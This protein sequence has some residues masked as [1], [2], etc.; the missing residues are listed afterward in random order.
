VNNESPIMNYC[1]PSLG[2]IDCYR[3]LKVDM[4]ND[5]NCYLA[6]FLFRMQ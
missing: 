4:I 5:F 3:A 1:S 2:L 6:P